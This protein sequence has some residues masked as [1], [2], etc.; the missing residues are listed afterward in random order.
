M[1]ALVTVAAL[2][3]AVGPYTAPRTVTRLSAADWAI[4][5]DVTSQLAAGQAPSAVT[6]TLTQVGGAAVT[7]PD[8]AVVTGNVVVQRVRADTL[9]PGLYLM[10]V[11][12]T[13]S[14]ST[15]VLLVATYIEVPF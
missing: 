8:A 14:G 6:V 9:T 4:G 1:S 7:L 5:V 12:F 10:S 3:L 13:P 2:P 11:A 15:D